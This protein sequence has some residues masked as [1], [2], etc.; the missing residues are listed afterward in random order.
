M[1]SRRQVLAMTLG[2]GGVGSGL[3]LG[4]SFLGARCI[5]AAIRDFRGQPIGAISVSGPAA[6]IPLER[7]QAIGA[8]VVEAAAKVEEGLGYARARAEVP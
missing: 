6:R 2:L 7:A 8:R 3:L 1:L 5:G 4:Y